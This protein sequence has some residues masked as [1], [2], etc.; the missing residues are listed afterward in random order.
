M[1]P[2][3]EA[4]APFESY[5]FSVLADQE[6]ISFFKK[7]WSASK[8]SSLYKVQSWGS[9]YFTVNANGHMVVRPF[10]FDT[11]PNEEIDILQALQTAME[12]KVLGDFS[13]FTP[14]IVRFPDVLKDRLGR[15]QSA[16]DAGI[17][18][19]HYQGHFQGVFPV[20]CNQDRFVVENIV[21]FGKPF[22][23]G[24]EAGSKPE[25][26]LAMSS[27][28]KG[29]PHALL[30]CNGYKDSDY[31]SLAL[32]AKKL[33]LN[34]VIVLEQ[35]EELDLVLNISRKLCIEPMIG[36]RA[37]L[38]TKH[39]GHFGET[40]GENGKFG[41]SCAQIVGIVHKLR[42]WKM[43]HCLQLLHFHMGSQVPSLSVL[44]D[45]VSEA[46]HI[47]CELSLMGANM[48]YI[49]IGGGLGV[50][51]DGSGS[52]ESDMSVGYT[53]EEYAKEVVLAVKMAC[54]MKGVKQ[55]TLCSESGRAL[56]SHHSVLVFNVL[57]SEEKNCHPVGDKGVSLEVDGTLPEPLCNLQECL[58]SSVRVGNYENALEYAHCMKLSSTGFFK[59]GAIN[60]MQLAFVNT[61]YEVVAAMVEKKR[62]EMATYD[63]VYGQCT[64]EAAYN[65][66]YHINLSIF[67]S[68]PDTWA[69]GQ[70][71]P[72]VPLHRLDEEPTVRAILSDLTCDSDGKITTFV[73]CGELSN[74]S[75]YMKV[76]PL[77]E[78][79]PYYVGMFLGGAYQ[80]ALGGMHN[81]FGA[82]PVIHIL[83]ENRGGGNLKVMKVNDGQNICDV[84]RGM[85]YEPV[86]M[87]ESLQL[88]VRNSLEDGEIHEQEEAMHM[89][90]C[91][92]FSSTYLS[93]NN[94]CLAL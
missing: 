19:L 26:L 88:K 73:G 9:S 61:L 38:N 77:Q 22:S 7:P 42:R 35:E 48:L 51:Y 78:G 90:D 71:F 80:E 93:N 46:A 23:F 14:L 56:V 89:L 62:C 85:Q 40:S 68:M 18:A 52:A 70:L 2:L 43:L 86:A 32:L 6:V 5:P 37:K 81:L 25:L 65:A 63:G 94:V 66:I 15:L 36:L 74:G 76:H 4:A 60:L 11:K 47:Y 24:L 53:M 29:S 30:V 57:S 41:L 10:G 34:C 54:Q 44:N 75:A 83:Q 82:P 39:D 28:S 33:K 12:D 3:A 21:E 79:K 59:K 13:P 55:P 92:F 49:D 84:L 1:P 16:F 27:L 72:I 50:D 8:S 67:K 91:S 58:A 87:L 20:K 17:K 64:K 69:I 31:V 45:G